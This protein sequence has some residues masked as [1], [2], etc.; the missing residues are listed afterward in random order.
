MTIEVE[1]HRLGDKAWPKVLHMMRGDILR[2]NGDSGQNGVVVSLLIAGGKGNTSST[3]R[4][5]SLQWV[6]GEGRS[7]VP[8]RLVRKAGGA[9]EVLIAEMTV[10]LHDKPMARARPTDGDDLFLRFFSITSEIENRIESIEWRVDDRPL[11]IESVVDDRCPLSLN[12]V[13]AGKHMLSGRARF[14]DNQGSVLIHPVAVDIA[15]VVQAVV[16]P[17]RNLINLTEDRTVSEVLVRV[18]P[19]AS[20]PKKAILQISVNGQ[21]QTVPLE[22]PVWKIPTESTIRE[23]YSIQPLVVEEGKKRVGQPV[24]LSIRRHLPTEIRIT[25]EAV[26]LIETGRIAKYLKDA[27]GITDPARL[28]QLTQEAL[29]NVKASIERCNAISIPAFLPEKARKA[30]GA[31]IGNRREIMAISRRYLEQESQYWSIALKEDGPFAKRIGL[32]IAA[33]NVPVPPSV[34]LRK[35]L[36]VR[37]SGDQGLEAEVESQARAASEDR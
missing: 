19:L 16:I 33:R 15:E 11:A 8:V 13:S 20:L 34:A 5:W 7:S 31:W 29:S 4:N 2:V 37:F 1:S 3:E 32:L 22:N 35:F 10:V 36:D 27:D 6:T 17:N 28:L 14:A 21:V 26:A 23:D 25:A 30:L 9:P 18:E 24:S 12:N